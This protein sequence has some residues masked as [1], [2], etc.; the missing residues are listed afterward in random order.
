[1]TIQTSL[2]TENAT[3]FAMLCVGD[4]KYQMRQKNT[5]NPIM[6][7][8][9]ATTFPS[10][11]DDVD[12]FI[13]QPSITTISKIGDTIELIPVSDQPT[14]KSKWAEKFSKT[15]PVKKD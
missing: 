3:E 15:R 5:S 1:M 4:K 14:K 7:L 9:P 6:I 8:Q 12:R 11:E 10:E 2:A 13:P